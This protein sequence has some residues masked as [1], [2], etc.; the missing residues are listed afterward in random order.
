M[1]RYHCCPLLPSVLQ[2][3]KEC[4]S[5]GQSVINK[6]TLDV[7]TKVSIS[8][9]KDRKRTLELFEDLEIDGDGER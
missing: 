7:L 4:L 3:L 9:R 8:M 6:E 5:I 1:S 2:V